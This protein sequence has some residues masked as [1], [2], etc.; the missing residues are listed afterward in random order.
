MSSVMKK[1]GIDRLSRDER[2]LLLEEI[3]DS[4]S[5]EEALKLSEAQRAELK[6]RSVDDDANPDDLVPWEDI[7]R[8]YPPFAGK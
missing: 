2:L 5:E 6:Q 4:I 7:K 1:L 3:W 8:M